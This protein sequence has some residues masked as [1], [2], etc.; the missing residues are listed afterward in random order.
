MNQLALTCSGGNCPAC[1]EA[2]P[3]GV[4]RCRYCHT[5]LAAVDSSPQI[6]PATTTA[7]DSNRAA[8]LP[9]IDDFMSAPQPTTVTTRPE[10]RMKQEEGAA[11]IPKAASPRPQSVP[12]APGQEVKERR[13][14]DHVSRPTEAVALA[15]TTAS[16]WDAYAESSAW[17]WVLWGSAALL[18]APLCVSGPVPGDP[19]RLSIFVSP[20]VHSGNEPHN[21]ILINSLVRDGD[22]DVLNNYA[23]VHQG[24]NQAGRKFAGW[25]L[26]HH[27]NWY[28]HSRLIHWWQAYEMEA[29]RWKKDADGHPVPTLK[30]DSNLR[31]VDTREY[32]QHSPGLAWVLAPIVWPFRKT[33]LLEPV[34]LLC[35]GLATV[36]G[37]WAFFSL[38][39]PSG[40][41][42]RDAVLITA[43][44]FLGT[45]LW[46]Y[47]RTLYL[48][49]YLM[50][51]AA[52]GYAMC[53]RFDRFVIAGTLL[54]IGTLIEIPFA[55]IALPLIVDY[56]FELRN[57]QAI[58]LAA[59]VL[60]AII[61]RL[62][63]NQRTFGGWFNF[64]QQWEWGYPLL[65]LGGL[66]FSWNHGLLMVAPVVALSLALGVPRW[67]KQQQREATVIGS[68]A[69]LY[70]LL[71]ASWLHWS[72]GSC[73]SAR[74]IVPVVPFLMLP[75]GWLIASPLW[76]TDGR[77]RALTW[78]LAAVSVTFGVVGAF[79][80]EHVWNKH[81]LQIILQG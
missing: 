28:W 68:A 39:R 3:A 78:S 5:S 43:V 26:D 59:P 21:L 22:I 48:E 42:T 61:L 19:S 81:P 76:K 12:Q 4:V 49:P 45:P 65:G 69:A 41:S 29:T 31:P 47:G 62:I 77:V 70:I 56:I 73:Y 14:R 79:A 10:K 9:D 80:C 8:A 40:L 71:M 2:M 75:I 34:T 67:V 44:T 36:A 63:C 38:L 64:P 55:V 57:R 27:V 53:L 54:G 52:T 35:S 74:C 25:A 17:L 16:Q 51:C 33:T 46:H 1:G 32:S 66:A 58:T 6:N 50:A 37:L 15:P 7:F 60:I 23:D 11:A 24:G 30:A 20:I 72:G 18:L 13:P